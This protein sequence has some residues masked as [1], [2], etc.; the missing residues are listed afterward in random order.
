M[1]R[2]SIRVDVPTFPKPRPKKVLPLLEVVVPFTKILQGEK[3]LIDANEGIIDVK[4]KIVYVLQVDKCKL[5]HEK[6]YVCKIHSCGQRL[7][8]LFI[9]LMLTEHTS[10]KCVMGTVM[11]DL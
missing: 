10:S 1:A 7:K 2:N 8:E 5:Y 6:L 9:S 3:K 11:N 4:F